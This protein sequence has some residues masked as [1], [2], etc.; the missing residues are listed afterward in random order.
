MWTDG[1]CLCVSHLP[2][3]GTCG[4]L[5]LNSSSRCCSLRCRCCS[6]DYLVCVRLYERWRKYHLDWPRS[7]F[8]VWTMC[9]RLVASCVGLIAPLSLFAFR[10]TWP[11]V[12]QLDGLSTLSMWSGFSRYAHIT[13]LP[14]PIRWMYSPWALSRY[15]CRLAER[16]Y[17]RCARPSSTRCIQGYEPDD[18]RRE[19]Q[20]V[21][22]K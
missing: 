8:R 15:L 10:M 22:C 20:L 9:S 5:R 2:I 6:H 4:G 1:P 16:E 21:R 14:I 18:T 7:M 12:C 17:G 13:G 19:Y 11:A 3:L